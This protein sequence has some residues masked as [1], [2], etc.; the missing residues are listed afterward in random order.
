[1]VRC[2]DSEPASELDKHSYSEGSSDD[3]DGGIE[4]ENPKV[5]SEP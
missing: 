5:Q 1:M 2:G 4:T 3:E